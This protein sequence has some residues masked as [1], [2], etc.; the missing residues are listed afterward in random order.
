M[1]SERSH[2][3]EPLFN[4]KPQTDFGKRHRG[5]CDP[6][7]SR[8]RPNPRCF[9][10]TVPPTRAAHGQVRFAG[11]VGSGARFASA[12]LKITQEGKEEKKHGLEFVS[13]ASFNAT[14]SWPGPRFNLLRGGFKTAT[15]KECTLSSW[16]TAELLLQMYHVKL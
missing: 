12:V 3:T 1:A 5:L 13:Q 10:A 15:P 7:I 4:G 11:A 6:I 9:L 14:L 8:S 2:D 16:A